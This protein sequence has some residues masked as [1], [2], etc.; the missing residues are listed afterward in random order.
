MDAM[1]ASGASIGN[2]NGNIYLGEAQLLFCKL[3]HGL[4]CKMDVA[5]LGPVSKQ[6]LPVND[7]GKC[8][9]L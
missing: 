2:L 1:A 6:V 8:F 7:V 4:S 3:H 5:F 9:Y